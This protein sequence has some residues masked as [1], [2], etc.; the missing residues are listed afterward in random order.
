MI[1]MV[2]LFR[3]TVNPLFP[4]AIANCQRKIFD[5]AKVYQWQEKYLPLALN[6]YTNIVK[7]QPFDSS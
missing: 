2:E 6:L 7:G 4:L 5:F 3:S 1:V